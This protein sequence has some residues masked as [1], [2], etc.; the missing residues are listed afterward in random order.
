MKLRRPSI[1]IISYGCG[2][3]ASLHSAFDKL[4]VDVKLLSTPNRINSTDFLVL[5]G[6]G[7]FGSAAERLRHGGWDDLIKEHVL[8]NQHPFLIHLKDRLTSGCFSFK[9]K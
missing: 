4:N 1:G 9:V 8:I 3:I 7:A 2:N 5:P 6:V